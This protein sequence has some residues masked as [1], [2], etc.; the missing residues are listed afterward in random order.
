MTATQVFMLF[1]K[2]ELS[3]SEYLFFMHHLSRRRR[4]GKVKPVLGKGFVE[5]YLSRTRRTLGGFMTRVF[6]LC[7][8]LLRCGLDNPT[9]KKIYD[10]IMPHYY[11]RYRITRE[12]DEYYF[13]THVNSKCVSV[14]RDRWRWFLEKHITSEKKFNSVY[15][16][17]ETYSYEY[18]Q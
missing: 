2:K 4:G 10:S 6:V 1:L 8:N 3:V 9:Y 12:E 11:G 13:K 16:E 5:E 18:K 7:P 14:Y 15:K 17:G